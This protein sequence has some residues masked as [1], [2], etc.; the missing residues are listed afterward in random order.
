MIELLHVKI[1]FLDCLHSPFGEILGIKKNTDIAGM[2]VNNGCYSTVGCGVRVD[3]FNVVH[4][5]VHVVII[6]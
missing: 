3:D 2:E 4:V 5:Q 1:P 6:G